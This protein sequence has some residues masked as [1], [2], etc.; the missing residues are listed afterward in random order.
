MHLR[1]RGGGKEKWMD[2]VEEERIAKDTVR[3]KRKEHREVILKEVKLSEGYSS[4]MFWQVGVWRER[5]E[6]LRN[7]ED[8]NGTVEDEEQAL[9]EKAQGGLCGKRNGLYEIAEGA[10]P[11]TG[12]RR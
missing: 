8:K 1:F 11:T 4:A 10:I 5:S 12:E 6:V 2:Y 7:L 3:R 9:A